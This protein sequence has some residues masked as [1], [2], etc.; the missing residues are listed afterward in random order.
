MIK[1]N[2]LVD[3]KG[4]KSKP[5]KYMKTINSGIVASKE[6]KLSV[7][8]LKQFIEQGR[9]YLAGHLIVKLNGRTKENIKDINFISLDIDNEYSDSNKEK[10][11][12]N[13]T[14]EEV[15]EKV[16][17][18]IGI[19]PIIS[20]TTFTGT[21]KENNSEKFRLIYPIKE[22][23]DHL[24]VELLLKHIV[25]S[26]GDIFDKACIDASRMFLGTDKPVTT[27][28]NYISVGKALIEELEV[29]EDKRTAQIEKERVER[30]VKRKSMNYDSTF[31]DNAIE[32]LKA[33]DLSD[34]LLSQGYTDIEKTSTGYKMPCPL[35]NGKDKN[36]HINLSNSI[37]LWICRSQCGSIGGTIID[38]HAELNNLT[39]AQA[40]EELKDMYNIKPVISIKPFKSTNA[41]TK[42][43]NI[44]KYISE[45]KNTVNS[46]LD[47]IKE[48]EKIL[49][50]GSLGI[51]K[52]HF[53][54][55]DLYK[56]AKAVNKVVIIIV[57][58]VKQLENL[59]NNKDIS[60]VYEKSPV[61]TGSK[62]VATTPESLP[63][64]VA[65][66]KADNYILVVDESHER[67]T[68]LYR[69]GYR[70][71]NIETAELDSFKSIHLTATPRLLE[72]DNFDKVIQIKAK[73]TI[74]NKITI[75]KVD[76][77]IE[78][79]MLSMIK[80]L[81]HAGRQP[82]LFNNNKEINKTLASQI[83]TK[84]SITIAEFERGQ[85][86]LLKE[87]SP[88]MI[89][90]TKTTI[91]TETIQSGK[92]SVNIEQGQIRED[93]TFTT[94]S[95]TAGVDLY[96]KDNA[97]LIINT[98]GVGFDN[99]IQLIG[100]F[101]KGIDVIIIVPDEDK[102]KP[103]F[104]L[105]SAIELRIKDSKEL[106]RLVNNNDSVK[107]LSEVKNGIKESANLE[108]N[109][110]GI[111]IVNETKVIAEV[112]EEWSSTVFNDTDILK[113][114][115]EQQDA[116][117]VTGVTVARFNDE[118]ETTMSDI[119]KA[120]KQEKKLK[121]E[122]SSQKLLSLS[123][124]NLY[125]VCHKNYEDLSVDIVE[126]A[127][128]YHALGEK[129]LEKIHITT[130]KLFTDSVGIEDVAGAF[131]HFYNNSWSSIKREIE[132]EDAREINRIIKENGLDL[133]LKVQNIRL[134]RSVDV[135]QAKIRYELH[136]IEQKQG[137]LSSKKFNE[138][139]RSLIEE[140]YIFNKNVGIYKQTANE[141][142][143]RKKAFQLISEDVGKQ[144]RNIY[145]LTND[146][147]ISSVK[148]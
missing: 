2:C 146:N 103:Y 22:S 100:R 88:K 19:K 73:E 111:W 10:I 144:I 71:K 32:D 66:V 38:L 62:L 27:Y 25:S 85:L 86:S 95:I 141:E 37:W 92:K 50:T 61:Y 139:I 6:L 134:K 21:N 33:I 76:K 79:N 36:F 3:T 145:N 43:I 13:Y 52:T 114:L 75:L 130:T 46:I 112:Y 18:E 108:I 15:I 125:K 48:N 81:D 82:I 148:A 64:I 136:E 42:T 4:Y 87:D 143:D 70:K 140:D 119:K 11:Y 49:M 65:D 74:S 104:E 34:Y 7:Q 113:Q 69:T 99:V 115:L 20:Y 126:V 31:S 16:E 8:Q 132:G 117:K 53:V 123:D 1:L 59:S 147:R 30:K 142:K 96:T 93:A 133:Y 41:G 127:D 110:N 56:Y 55:N 51:G 121:L 60:V 120:T 47:I 94:S 131:R 45:D 12:T 101:R 17:Q 5:L 122:K 44:D 109:D 98:H 137:R 9:T 91:T 14:V 135:V 40:I 67:Y 24:Q 129:H 84:E 102:R 77:N 80:R 90:E 23:I 28:D 128:L 106:A 138:L 39:T 68:S 116:F 89:T 29:A 83:E 63:K 124:D 35:H 54:L 26:C 105:Q 78:D 72:N 97:T 58:S 118:N 57:P 107:R